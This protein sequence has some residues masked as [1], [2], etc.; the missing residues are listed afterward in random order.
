MRLWPKALFDY[1]KRKHI[2]LTYISTWV[3]LVFSSQMSTLDKDD[4]ENEWAKFTRWKW[5]RIGNLDP[6]FLSI[7]IFAQLAWEE[8]S[9][10]WAV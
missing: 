10:S 1:K 8:L 4:D 2:V 6:F 7:L 9:Q 3:G 5:K